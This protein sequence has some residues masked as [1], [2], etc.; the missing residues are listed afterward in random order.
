MQEPDKAQ[1]RAF[2]EFVKAQRKLAQISQRNL[3]RSAGFSDSYLSQLE[4]GQY[5]P[6]AQTVRALSNAIGVPSSVLLAQ[7]GLMDEDES[8]NGA[9]E[10]A[11]LADT[12]LSPSQREALITVYRS[13][14]AAA[15]V[16]D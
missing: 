5:M 10:D 12:R 16:S 1:L 2:G 7:L 15:G 9:V 14:L 8:R 13:Y 3:A 4:R 6:S 11:I